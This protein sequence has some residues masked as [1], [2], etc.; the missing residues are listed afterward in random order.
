MRKS[1]FIDFVVDFALCLICAILW[2][3]VVICQPTVYEVART[4]A[5]KHMYVDPSTRT[6]SLTRLHSILPELIIYSQA[7]SSSHQHRDRQ[8]CLH[9]TQYRHFL[10]TNSFYQHH[11]SKPLSCLLPSRSTSFCTYNT[12]HCNVL[13]F[14]LLYSLKHRLN[15]ML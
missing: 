12:V 3:F 11:F 15:Y 14:L 7:I 2:T 6:H 1:C 8:S 9:F 13:S 10:L 5:H 4:R